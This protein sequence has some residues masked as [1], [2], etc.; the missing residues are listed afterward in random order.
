MLRLSEPQRIAE[1]FRTLAN[2]MATAFVFTN[3]LTQQ[4]PSMR[5]I[6]AGII[7]WSILTVASLRLI[8]ER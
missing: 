4:S 7:G 3:L 1:S 2:L 6:G 5:L 8:G